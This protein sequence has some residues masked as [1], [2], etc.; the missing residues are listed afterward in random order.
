[1]TP[2]ALFHALLLFLEKGGTANGVLITARCHG[3][4]GYTGNLRLAGENSY[5]IC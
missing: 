3:P 1:M 4:C 5:N 2:G